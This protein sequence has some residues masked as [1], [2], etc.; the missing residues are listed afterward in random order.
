MGTVEYPYSPHPSQHIFHSSSCRYKAFVGAKGSGKTMTGC[1]EVMSLLNEFPGNV[2][3]IARKDYPALERSTMTLFLDWLPK[4]MLLRYDKQKRRLY[5]RSKELTKPSIL[6]FVQEKEPKE[7]DSMN[8]GLF[9]IDEADECPFETFKTLTSRLR[10]KGIP[11]Y[12]LIATNPPNKMHWI[13]RFF[14]EEPSLDPSIID[15]ISVHNNTFENLKNL[16]ND[17]VENLKRIYSGDELNRFLYGEYGSISNEWQVF[18]DW[19]STIHVSKEPLKVITGLPIIR[20]WDFGMRAGCLYSQLYDGQLRVL[21]EVMEFNKGAEQFVPL[22]LSREPKMFKDFHFIDLSDPTY[23]GNRSV[24][25]VTKSCKS[26]LREHGIIISGGTTDWSKRLRG[27]NYFMTRQRTGEPC[28]YVDSRCK[29]LIAGFEGGYRFK[30]NAYE[31]RAEDIIKDQY[32]ELQD[33]LQ[34]TACYSHKE[35]VRNDGFMYDLPEDKYD[36]SNRSQNW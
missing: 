32:S 15:R 24:V 3:V 19:R 22:V 2:G 9:F 20:A 17:Y 29:I 30:E 21:R 6:Y 31:R 25:D 18:S 5:I 4:E 1:I 10:I 35:L 16:P 27:V 13:Y 11:N 7:F 8:I 14:E 26:I 33:C 34:H 12:G 28:L 36:F 23:V